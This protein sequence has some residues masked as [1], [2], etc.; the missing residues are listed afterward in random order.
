MPPQIQRLV[1][2]IRE[3]DD[4]LAWLGREAEF[5]GVTPGEYRPVAPGAA[6]H[7]ELD[8]ERGR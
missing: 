3:R 5:S 2:R 6:L 4:W 1:A 8:G 7:M